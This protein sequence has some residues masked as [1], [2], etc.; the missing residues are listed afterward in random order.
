MRIFQIFIQSVIIAVFACGIAQAGHFKADTTVGG[1]HIELH[2]LPA[3]PFFTKDQVSAGNVKEGMMIIGGARPLPL[4]AEKK[5]THHLV[6]HVFDSL[7]A[8]A[9]TN[10]KVKMSY[11]ALD[12]KGNYA[13]GPIEV[14]VVVMQAVGKGEESTHYGNNV[15]M[16]D[17]PYVVDVSV[18]GSTLKFKL[19][20]L[21]NSGPSMDYMPGH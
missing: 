16:L 10:A 1:M 14:P 7:S 11:Q 20:H 21:F 12:K 19:D 17:G 3:E 15:V 6:I 2:V 13:G 8:K 4:D 9:I 18:N 5:P